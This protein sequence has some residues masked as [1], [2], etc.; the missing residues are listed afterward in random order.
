M[1]EDEHLETPEITVRTALRTSSNRAAVR[2][3]QTLGMRNTMSYVNKLNFGQVPAVPSIALGAGEV[4]LQSLTAAYAAFA[5]G[6][7][8][9]KP[10]LIRRVEDRDGKVLASEEPQLTRAF[11]ETTAFLM[12]NMLSDVV[13]AGT[14]YRARATGFN[15]PAAGKTGTT[16]DFVDA[17]FVGFTPR[18]VA[19]VWM[20]FDQPQ[21]IVANGYGG[22]LAVPVWGEFMKVA[23]KGDKPDWL[24]RPANVVG[25]DTCRMSGKRPADG[26]RSVTVVKNGEHQVRS[27]VYTEYFVSGTEPWDQ[28]RLH[29]DPGLFQRMAGLFGSGREPQ[30]VAIESSGL[31]P[32]GAES[33]PP[34]AQAEPAPQAEKPTATSAEPEKKKRGFWSRLFGKREKDGKEKKPQPD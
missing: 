32:T 33:P 24:K 29:E 20:G 5:N 26:C 30:P 21:T 14:G 34:A 10:V 27:M 23:T 16:N 2:V 25:V 17:W 3:L 1:P 6:G 19:G 18:L 22:E 12:A 13:N 28:C 31:P 11:S 8:V 4:T 15:L 7:S 9:V